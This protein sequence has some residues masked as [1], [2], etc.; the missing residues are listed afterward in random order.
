MMINITNKTTD[1]RIWL[2]IS[3][4]TGGIIWSDPGGFS[5]VVM[6]GLETVVNDDLIS[7]VSSFEPGIRANPLDIRWAAISK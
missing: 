3:G 6:I 4:L 7:V 2:M 5:I 1:L